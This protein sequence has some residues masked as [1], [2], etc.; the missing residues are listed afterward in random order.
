MTFT[1][2]VVVGHGTLGVDT[3]EPGTGVDT[4]G[5][6]TGS[7]LGTV[8]A[9]Q[10]LRLALQCGVSLVVPDTLTHS[11]ATLNSAVSVDTTGVWI[12]GLAISVASNTVCTPM[13]SCVLSSVPPLSAITA[14]NRASFPC[15]P[16]IP[17]TVD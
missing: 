4:L 13:L 6:D 1:H 11:L 5:V 15:T 14:T 16:R 2:G 7:V 8:V 10:T 3:T 12:A 9:Q 17:G